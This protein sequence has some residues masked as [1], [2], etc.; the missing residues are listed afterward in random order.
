MAK[1]FWLQDMIDAAKVAGQEVP[2]GVYLVGDREPTQAEIEYGLT[3]EPLARRCLG[4]DGAH[5]KA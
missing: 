5:E 2:V 4:V 1:R 3:L